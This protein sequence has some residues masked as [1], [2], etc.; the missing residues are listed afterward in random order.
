MLA[1][2][3]AMLAP[4]TRTRLASGLVAF[5][6]AWLV[7]A[8][9]AVANDCMP[10]FTQDAT[11]QPA[12][13]GNRECVDVVQ[14]PFVPEIFGPA[15]VPVVPGPSRPSP[16]ISVPPKRPSGLVPLFASYVVLQALDV[17][18][19]LTVLDAGGVEQN[20]FMNPF[21]GK[22]AAFIAF[23]AG[24]TAATLLAAD[25]LS[26]HNRAASYVLMAALNSAYVAVVAHNYRVAA[27][28][29]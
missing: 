13:P 25:R 16:P 8:A 10:A 19:T 28:L 20:M 21:V 3:G 27:Q 11:A 24:L 29:R 26:R 22:P 15:A 4:S 17:H 14:P 6:I 5:S 12:A 18:S 2:K 9:R 7:P 23:K 1:A